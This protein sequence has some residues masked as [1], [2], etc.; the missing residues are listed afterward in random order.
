MLTPEVIVLYGLLSCSTLH[1]CLVTSDLAEVKIVDLVVSPCR[2]ME[3]LLT[4]L[5]HS[6]KYG[7]RWEL[8]KAQEDFPIRIVNV[9]MRVVRFNR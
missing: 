6:V 7:Y 3:T 8:P 4:S 1:A 2:I 9:N 5:L